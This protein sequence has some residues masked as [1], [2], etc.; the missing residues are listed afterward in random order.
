MPRRDY[1]ERIADLRLAEFGSHRE[2]M[3]RL[4]VMLTVCLALNVATGDPRVLIWTSLYL[5]F[6]TLFAWMSCRAIALPPRGRYAGALLFYTLSGLTFLSLTIYFIA[7]AKTPALVFVGCAGITGL[8]L[9][10]LRRTDREI[11]LSLSDAGQALILAPVLMATLWPRLP[12]LDDRLLVLVVSGATLVYYLFSLRDGLRQHR[13]RQDA[14]QRYAAAQKT[15]A[16]GQFAGGV[17]HDFNNRL[18]AILGNLELA[19]ML[20][21]PKDRHAAL[22][23]CHEAATRAAHTVQQLLTACGRQRLSPADLDVADVLA[24]LTEALQGLLDSGITVQTGPQPRGQTLRADPDLLEACAIQ[25]CLNARD[26]MQGRGTIRIGAQRLDSLPPM[27]PPPDAAP[28]LVALVIEDDGPGVS[29]EDLPLLSEPF[30]TTKPASQNRG[31]GLSTVAGFARQSGGALWLD[32]SPYGGLKAQI[33][34]PRPDVPCSRA[35]DG[36]DQLSGS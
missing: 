33:L 32:H 28:P 36:P 4:C 7:I 31:L 12:G 30:Y 5:L 25:L 3:V 24:N 2:P 13:A 19:E 14:R 15:R 22:R 29:P 26:A 16:L 6:E 11:G 23:Q 8:L 20:E 10:T 34:L 9:Y 27:H 18:T 17:A 35:R 1:E 21:D